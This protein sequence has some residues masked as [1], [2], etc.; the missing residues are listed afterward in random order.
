MPKPVR[1]ALCMIVKPDDNEAKM[2]DRCLE[3]IAPHVDGIFLTITGENA[4][5]DAVA[6]KHKA[7]VAKYPWDFSF[8]NA[9][10]FALKQVPADFTHWCW[11]DCDDMV[12]GVEH[13]KKAIVDNPM[14]DAFI[15]RYLYAFDEWKNATIVHLKTRILKHDG[16]VEWA[17]DLHEDFKE[18]R[19][20]DAKLLEDVEVLHLS[21]DK[22]FGVS[23]DRNLEIAMKGVEK[24]PDDP[25]SY[26]N[27]AN[28]QRGAGD[29]DGSLATFRKFLTVSASEEEQFIAWI[30]IS[31]IH[32]I[33]GQYRDALQTARLAIGLRPTYPDGYHMAGNILF[34]LKRYTDAR[35]HF[36]QG[37]TMK[38]PYNNVVVYNPRAYDYEPMMN[39]SKTYFQLN[40]PALALILLEACA[41]IMPRDEKLKGQVAAM[42]RAADDMEKAMEQI[43]RLE[44]ITDDAKLKEEM[45]KLPQDMQQHPAMLTLRNTRFVK[46]E[47]SGRDLVFYCGYTE[48]QWNPTIARE[49]G[50]GGSEEAV[51]HLS[52][53]LAKR[54]WNVTV[55]ANC[56]HKEFTDN[57]V[58][59]KPFWSWN[60]R[61]KQDATIIWRIPRVLDYEINCSRIFLDMHDAVDAGEMTPERV[62]KIEKIFVK[63]NAHR[64]LYPQVPDEKFAIVP[65]GIVWEDLQGNE[66]EPM[67]IVNTSSPDRSILPLLKGFARVKEQVPGARLEWAYGWNVWDIVQGDNPQA[68]EW[69]KMVAELIAKTPGVKALGRVSH[70]EVAK[71][72]RRASVFGYPTA[73]YEI[74]CISARKAQAAGC[75]MVTTDFAALDETVEHG[76]KVHVLPERE[77][78]GKPHAFDFGLKDE[79]AIDEWVVAT[80][81]AL[82]DPEVIGERKKQAESMKRFGWDKIA[83]RWDGILTPAKA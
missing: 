26:W 80:V 37:L 28:A 75:R 78:W 57:G 8:A 63:S 54:G 58:T 45:E 52:A 31:E 70:G 10:N 11:F 61:D 39:L 16:C 27:L 53:Q 7:T 77:N 83:E 69:R 43:K 82:T 72:Y 76:H 33:K 14:T 2:L 6:L 47:T 68:Q 55:Y 3:H 20:L 24:K 18:N 62:K 49:K 29:L 46:K 13:M 51:I 34:H 48:E 19:R 9:R 5:C 67:L 44:T 32:F 17:G 64:V 12:R 30:R 42:K 22:R 40:Q 56:G 15:M 60:S 59:W 74:D 25:R 1:L 4:M 73:F 23:K 71:L 38:P 79:E 66:R 81:K 50:I 65:N 35:D 21:D 36:Q 41:K